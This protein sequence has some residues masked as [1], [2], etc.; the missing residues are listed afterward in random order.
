MNR[1]RVVGL[2]RSVCLSP[3]SS[4]RINVAPGQ[5]GET[6]MTPQHQHPIQ[7]QQNVGYARQVC[8]RI[9]RDGGKPA[10]ALKAFKLD[11]PHGAID[12][13]VAVDRI[14]TALSQPPVLRKAA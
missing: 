1:F 11:A 9:F 10:D 12:W 13:S 3:S 2:E 8:A 4:I 7:W 14:A 5:E 6:L